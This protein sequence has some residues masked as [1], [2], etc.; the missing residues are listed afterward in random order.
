MQADPS[1]FGK[2]EAD[3]SASAVKAEIVMKLASGSMEGQDKIAT[4]AAE[5]GKGTATEEMPTETERI[6]KADI[7]I[8][9][10]PIGALFYVTGKGI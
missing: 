2:G 4:T 6:N 9:Q 1:L 3:E 7:Y 10:R 5:T 8:K